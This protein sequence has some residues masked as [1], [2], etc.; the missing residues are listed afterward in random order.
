MIARAV[1]D[2]EIPDDVPVEDAERWLRF[3]LNETGILEDKHPSL[4]WVIEPKSE[5]Q[6]DFIKQ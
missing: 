6:I 5:I 1:F 3:T 2:V 4:G